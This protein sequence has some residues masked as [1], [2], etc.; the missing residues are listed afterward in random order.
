[1]RQP[2][3]KPHQSSNQNDLKDPLHEGPQPYEDHKRLDTDLKPTQSEKNPGIRLEP[4]NL[5]VSDKG[6]GN[7]IWVMTG[8]VAYIAG[9]G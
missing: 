2:S 5:P 9:F 7:S 1:M 4:A 3:R 6:E 8:R